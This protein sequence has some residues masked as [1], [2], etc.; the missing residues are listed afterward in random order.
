M[1]KYIYIYLTTFLAMQTT[2]CAKILSDLETSS[3]QMKKPEARS[4]GTVKK[5]N[6]DSQKLYPTTEWL[7][8]V[9]AFKCKVD[10]AKI[11]A[12]KGRA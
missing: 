1:N 11:N 5:E 6:C 10:V 7:R 9:V 2:D 3:S 4:P 12:I 8:V